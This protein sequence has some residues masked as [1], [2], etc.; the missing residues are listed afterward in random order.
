MHAFLA[1]TRNA[2]NEALP[3]DGRVPLGA[4]ASR[5]QQRRDDG[6]ESLLADELLQPLQ[7]QIFRVSQFVAHSA[8]PIL[9]HVPQRRPFY[10]QVVFR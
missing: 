7:F 9:Q 1:S 3:T 5:I 10:G 2:S 8:L 4:C 6:R